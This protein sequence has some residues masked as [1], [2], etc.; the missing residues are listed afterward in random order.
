M[1]I[2]HNQLNQHL[3][4]PIATI[5]LIFGDEPWQKSDALGQIRLAAAQ[6]GFSE[7]ISLTADDKFDWQSLVDEYMTMSLFASQRI[8]EVECLNKIND[9]GVKALQAL[10][11][12]LHSDV[13]LILHGAKLD[14]AT[15]NKKWFKQ[16]S[17]Q[18]VY[19][20]VYDMD[21]RAIQQWLNRQCRHYQ[22]TLPNDAQH[23]LI[24]LFEG[25]VLALDQELQKLSILFA[26]QQVSAEE[27]SQLAI[28]QAK[29]NPFQLVDTLLSGDVEKCLNILEQ[30][31]QE[32][33]PVGQLIWF[34]H[35][36][37]NTLKAMLNEQAQGASFDTLCKQHR[38]WKNKQSLYRTALVKLTL[39][40]V[41]FALSR[42]AD[43]D[44]ISKTSSDFDCYLLL[45]ELCVGL[46]SQ[47]S[48]ED[49]PLNYEF[50]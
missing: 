4:Q 15:P 34:I 29:F 32:G 11:E 30:L 19:L 39:S 26:N 23:I 27:I 47:A 49:F 17:E 8:I 7:K 46:L 43:I 22:L 41:N 35:K 40:K 6:Q 3:G 24:E 25:N 33:S 9:S 13:V 38:I 12:Q 20:P 2:Y 45:S 10:L 42:L 37:L 16:F 28:K 31:K 5:W 1:R 14:T 50:E 21:T 18:G 36:E 44:L 48:F